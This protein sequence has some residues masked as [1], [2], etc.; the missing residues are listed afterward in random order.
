TAAWESLLNLRPPQIVLLNWQR[1][2]DACIK[3]LR[4]LEK[5]I[6]KSLPA[7]GPV[8]TGLVREASEDATASIESEPSADSATIQD[9]KLLLSK[10]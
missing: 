8:I 10:L 3:L 2:Y 6:D 5:A 7:D 1:F 9:F 4:S